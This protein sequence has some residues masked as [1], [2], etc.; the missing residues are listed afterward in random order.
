MALLLAT[1][2]ACTCSSIARTSG[3]SSN[4]RE[5]VPSLTMR[6]FSASPMDRKLAEFPS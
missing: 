3:R 2:A 5:T 4:A 1:L 6:F